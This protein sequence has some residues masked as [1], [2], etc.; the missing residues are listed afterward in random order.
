MARAVQSVAE[1]SY[2]SIELVIINDGGELVNQEAI[3]LPLKERDSEITLTLK[4]L[5][6][7]EGRS[8][9]ANHA[10]ELARGKYFI[11]LDDDDWIASEHLKYLTDALLSQPSLIAAYS[12]TAC[13]RSYEQRNQ[14]SRVYREE[15]S[16]N[17]LAAVNYLPIH[18]VLFCREAFDKGCKF[19]P[20]LSIYEDW[21]FW[22]QVATKGDFKRVPQLTAYY[23][24]EFS[25]VGFLDNSA[26]FKAHTLL[27]FQKA[28]P[29]FTAD[30]IATLQYSYR[31][32]HNIASYNYQL[33]QQINKAQSLE[34]TLKQA[35]DRL[36]DKLCQNLKSPFQEISL[37]S[38]KKITKLNSELALLKSEYQALNDSIKRFKIDA[39]QE[40]LEVKNVLWHINQRNEDHYRALKN[41][42]LMRLKKISR[43]LY[44]KGSTLLLLIRDR[45][46]KAIK[47]KVAYNFP[48]LK[49]IP[50]IKQHLKPCSAERYIHSPD[51]SDIAGY[52]V[53]NIVT[54]K[55][56]LF[57]AELL[58]KHLLSFGIKV[59][60][61]I[62][63]S[64]TSFCD[65][66]H[67]VI[68]PQMCSVLPSRYISFQMEQSVSSRWFDDNYFTILENS[69]AIFDYSLRNIRYIQEMSPIHYKQIYYL[70]ISNIADYFDPGA[71]IKKEYDVVFYGDI[72]NDRRKRFIDAISGKYNTLVISDLFG[73]DLYRE[74]LKGKL[75][76][77]IHYYENALLETTRLHEAVSL[78]I[79]VIT[80]SSIDIDEHQKLAE[81]V[82]VTPI[83][84][85]DAML[86]AIDAFLKKDNQNL[87][88][89]NDDMDHFHFHLGR[90]LLGCGMITEEQAMKLE[91]PLDRSS[92]EKGVGLSL[93]ESWE[94]RIGFV[95]D[96]PDMTCFPGLRHR[97]SWKGCAMSYKYLAHHALNSGMQHIEIMEDDVLLPA[98]ARKRWES[99]K[100]IFH[101]VEFTERHCDLL[102]G[103][104]ADVSDETEILDFF[105]YEGNQYVIIDRMISAVCNYYGEYPLNLIARWNPHNEDIN[106]NTMDRYL[107]SYRLRVLVPMPFIAGHKPDKQS[108]LWSFGNE[109][110]DALISKSM[111]I[112][113]KKLEDFK[114]AKND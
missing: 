52:K 32:F 84:D 31:E 54:P 69:I 82:T 45:D 26:D 112:L 96:L 33:E 85:L 88:P 15:F 53:F 6:Q 71:E 37:M 102:S 27:F 22:I 14:L 58:K 93:P 87:S 76:V 106:T 89:V 62:D 61:I 80:E 73:A 42:Y 104:L 63:S 40:L 110:Y 28:V 95:Q 57:V 46:I 21:H 5:E 24:A 111:G 67:V 44:S 18:S 11:F 36:V 30:Q 72:R 43:Q 74:L 108:T 38:E 94:R 41:T 97:D 59:D 23:S 105:E 49:R 34:L 8:A 70:P 86:E 2:P 17:A 9:A 51:F 75:L 66:V 7:N 20:E 13:V 56:T 64:E 10:M 4:Q 79:P 12:D 1:Q 68:A 19:D 16:R 91:L 114:K 3:T 48:L 50:L 92:L 55:H 47:E 39:N 90:A 107:E 78:G 29:F 98:A 113:T 77:N 83:D 60:R 103:L 100:Q 101:S 81:Q 65:R 109:T 25:G 35:E 99:A